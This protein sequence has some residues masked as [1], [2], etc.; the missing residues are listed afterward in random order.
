LKKLSAENIQIVT[1]QFFYQR[2]ASP[3]TFN[4]HR[5]FPAFKSRFSFPKV[6]KK[7]WLRCAMKC[8]IVGSSKLTSKQHDFTH[9]DVAHH[10]H[11]WP[12]IAVKEC[13][14]TVKK[15]FM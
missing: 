9:P 4:I 15:P 5:L 8:A 3:T 6:G 10:H 11:F 13:K 7:I 2:I 14:F 1:A 12:K